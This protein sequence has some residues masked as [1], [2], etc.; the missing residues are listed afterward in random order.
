ME[1]G[2]G[3]QE[4]TDLLQKKGFCSIFKQGGNTRLEE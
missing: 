3:P 2:T 1:V 4:G